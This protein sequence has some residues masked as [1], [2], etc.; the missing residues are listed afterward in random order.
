MYGL[1][2]LL[3]TL[4]LWTDQRDWLGSLILNTVNSMHYTK[5]K[6]RLIKT[7]LFFIDCPFQMLSKRTVQSLIRWYL[8]KREREP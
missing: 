4:Y 7:R 3:Y 8:D 2:Y 1:R 6:S 5:I